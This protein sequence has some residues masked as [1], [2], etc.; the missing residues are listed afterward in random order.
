MKKIIFISIIFLLTQGIIGQNYQ[1]KINNIPFGVGILGGINTYNFTGTSFLIEGRINLIP[2]LN[3]KMSI[4]YSTI[5]KKGYHVNTNGYS[6][7]ENQ[8]GTLSYDIDFFRYSTVPIS[9][10]LEYIFTRQ[11][12][13]PYTSF[14]IGYNFY[15]YKTREINYFVGKDGYFDNFEDLPEIYKNDPPKIDKDE[16]FRMSL[17]IGTL[18]KLSS[19][20]FLDIRYAYQINT[21]LVNTH[22]FLIGIQ[23]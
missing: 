18:Y 4:G 9:L 22:Q 1:E 13:T 17:G 20:F 11:I 21:N 10:G 15:E 14:E 7:F 2:D 19:K 6:N 23:L 16:S 5:Y 12:F 8:F 3:S